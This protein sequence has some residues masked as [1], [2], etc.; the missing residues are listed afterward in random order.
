LVGDEATVAAQQW[1]WENCRLAVEPGAATPVAALLSGA[2]KPL[3]DEHIAVLVCGANVD[4]GTVTS[5]Q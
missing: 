2:Y 4:P 3:P 5:D 1:L